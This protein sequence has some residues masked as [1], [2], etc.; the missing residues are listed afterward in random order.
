MIY[1]IVAYGDPVLKK[2]AEDFKEGEDLKALIADMYE[3][4]YNASGV[5]LAAPQIGLSKR[6]F[7]IDTGAFEETETE[8]V[9]R[10]FI[11]PEILEE[12][13]EE[14]GYEEGCLSIPGIRAVVERPETVHIRYYDEN[15]KLHEEAFDGMT[16]RVIQHEYDHLE[17]VLFTDYLSPLKKRLYKS[18]LV[19]ISKG[20]T[21]ASYR[22][23]FPVKR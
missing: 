16:A 3:T 21:D 6:I 22:M 11:N 12:T 9:K 19:N 13:G 15:W 23:R 17:G 10:A 5:G 20:V 4:M 7:V 2:V 1:P 8:A 14:W 18:K